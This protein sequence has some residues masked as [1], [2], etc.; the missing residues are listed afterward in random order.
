MTT[1][2]LPG[3]DLDPPTAGIDLSRPRQPR[4][5]PNPYLHLHKPHD[6]RSIRATHCLRC[7]APIVVGDDEDEIAVTVKLD[8]T[9]LSATGEMAAVLAG[10]A[11]YTL[12]KP[13]TGNARIWRRTS[14]RI[15]AKPAD[16]PP[17]PWNQYDVLPAH[18]CWNPVAE[19]LTTKTRLMPP[20]PTRRNHNE[21][22]PF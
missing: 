3:L 2:A 8:V 4:R 15:K 17:R 19:N 22:P 11:T 12:D 9:P 21:P 6:P 16:K 10:R 5:Q 13:I 1:P 18:Q 20:P 7:R 14:W